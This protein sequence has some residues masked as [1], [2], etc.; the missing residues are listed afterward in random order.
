MFRNELLFILSLKFFIENFEFYAPRK[1]LSQI[2]KV[3][4]IYASSN[5]FCLYTI[6]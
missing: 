3:K 6:I 2:A 4:N 1:M 5:T